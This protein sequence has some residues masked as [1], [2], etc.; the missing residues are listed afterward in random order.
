MKLHTKLISLLILSLAIVMIIIQFIQYLFITSPIANSLDGDLEILQ[1]SLITSSLFS[2]ISTVI[3][4]GVVYFFLIRR[5][6][7]KPIM[8]SVEMLRE[9]AEGEGDL[10]KRLTEITSDEFGQMSKWFNLFIEKVQDI[11][12][13]ITDNSNT[14]N[15]YSYELRNIFN[16]MT[17]G[18]EQTSTKSDTVAI[19]I[20]IMNSK[21]N[22]IVSSMEQASKNVTMAATSTDEMASTIND[23]AQNS[24]KASSITVEAVKEANIA[25]DNVD[26]LGSAARAIEKVTETISEISDQTNL[27]A[28]NA[29]I[30]AARAGESG[31]GFAVVANE[32][33]ELARQTTSAA[34]EIKE[35]IDGIQ[36]STDSAV[37]GIKRISKVIVEMDEIVSTIA[38]A[39]NEQH[40]TTREIA[41][42]LSQTSL[43]IKEVNNSVIQSSTSYKDI[44]VDIREV[45]EIS[46][47]MSENCSL[48][49]QNAEKLE[50]LARQIKDMVESFKI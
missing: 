7:S 14:L 45:Y 13:D 34:F 6:I 25:S 5:L 19:S 49:N 32:I 38:A 24:S 20:E 30:E 44:S 10:T 15:L 9:I 8:T 50:T 35:K 27:L 21:M 23:I 3:I 48:A 46:S 37:N 22:Q 33:K 17:S 2:I 29:T 1:K 18:V 12:S 31:K 42:N 36:N 40:A 41:K 39:V 28:L 47:D 11:I 43:G 4:L 16:R 26:E